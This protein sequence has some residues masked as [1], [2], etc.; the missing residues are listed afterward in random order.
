MLLRR[1]LFIRGFCLQNINNCR[2]RDF[3]EAVGGSR[4]SLFNPSELNNYGS[5]YLRTGRTGSGVVEEKS[6]VGISSHFFFCF[7]FEVHVGL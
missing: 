7:W 1:L 2:E 6:G 4:C 3:P 5:A